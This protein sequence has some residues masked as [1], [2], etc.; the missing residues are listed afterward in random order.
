MAT[1]VVPHGG[2]DGLGHIVEIAHDLIDGLFRECVVT[3]ERFVEIGHIG[4][5]VAV[6]VNRHRLRVDVRFERI[7]RIRQGRELERSI[8]R[9]GSSGRGGFQKLREQAGASGEQGGALESLAT[10]DHMF[11]FVGVLGGF[12]REGQGR[13]RNRWFVKSLKRWNIE[14]LNR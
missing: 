10:G 1:P 6:V 11:P 12:C 5:V 14:S 8:G 7:G 2:A 9:G 13:A 4:G 3:H